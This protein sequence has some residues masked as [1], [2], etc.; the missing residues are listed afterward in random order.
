MRPMHVPG[1]VTASVLRVPARAA[2]LALD[3]LVKINSE[4]P[5]EYRG[6]DH[7]I[8]ELRADIFRGTEAEALTHR[9]SQ[10]LDT[11]ARTLD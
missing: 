6:C 3:L 9:S 5:S 10:T 8:G 2:Q 11:L 7:H 4:L 1:C